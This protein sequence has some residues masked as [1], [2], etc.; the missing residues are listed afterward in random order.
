MIYDGLAKYY[1]D[2]V[3]D[4]EATQKWVDFTTQYCRGKKILEL[5]CG[6]GEIS[7]ALKQVGY[8]ILATDFSSSMIQR[9]NQKYPDVKTDVVDMISFEMNEKFDG[10]LCYCDSINYLSSLDDIR[11]MFQSVTNCLNDEGVFIFDMHTQDRLEEFSELY[12]EEGEL[13]VPYQWTIQ[14][15]DQQIHQHFAF[16]E[17]NHILQEQHIQTVFDHTEVIKLLNDLGF[18]C[19]IFT[20]F[21]HRGVQAGEKLFI[22]ARREKC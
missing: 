2:L 7:N 1:D 4:E 15:I 22:V 19:D 16:F 10:V 3:A 12:I 5:A 13:D 18:S 14:S 17:E 20:D 9:L 11:S 6:S 8:D 21:I